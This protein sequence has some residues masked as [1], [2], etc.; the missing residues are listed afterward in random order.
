MSDGRKVVIATCEGYAG[1]DE[2]RYYISGEAARAKAE[3]RERSY[4]RKD[5]RSPNPS[6]W[7]SAAEYRAPWNTVIKMAQKRALVGAAIVATAASGLFTQDM[8]DM[9]PAATV[10]V[11]EAAQAS[12]AALP[13]DV[14]TAL[15]KWYRGKRWPEPA[16]WT[17]VQW[18]AALQTTGFL[19]ARREHPEPPPTAAEPA[20][21]AEPAPAAPES[22]EWLDKALEKASG[23]TLDKAGCLALWK[24][25]AGKVHAGKIGKPD[26]ARVQDYLRARLADLDRETRIKAA[27]LEDDDPW[28]VKIEALISRD[29]AEGALAEI[30]GQLAA[31]HI[32]Q[33]RADRLAAAIEVRFPQVQEERAAA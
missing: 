23:N 1:Y 27:A 4:A 22:G 19:A 12:I 26:A 17:P 21:A 24:E 13:D 8:E 32:D 11:A 16:Q 10:T 14:Q 2:D 31:G 3:A 5:Q 15:V 9:N 33:A 25:S 18:C 7:E 20:S 29:E 30:A 28:A 6:K